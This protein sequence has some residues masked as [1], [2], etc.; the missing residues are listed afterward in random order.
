MI[1]PLTIENLPEYAEVIRQSFATVADDFGITPE[2]CPLHNVFISDETLAERF[3]KYF[4][5][6][7]YFIDKKLIGFVSLTDRG[8]NIFE[9][10]LLSI[11]PSYRHLGYGK[12]MVDFCK[13][14][15]SE[16]GGKK[17]IISIWEKHT[18]LKDW[19]TANNFVL[20]EA[21]TVD[22]FPFPVVHMEWKNKELR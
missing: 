6:F 13:K 21:K 3:T 4:F 20:I 10:N 19:Y 5:P 12:E 7:G 1:R 8:E 18:R 9:M 17:I 2:N 11:L 14:K 22:F 15:I 16:R